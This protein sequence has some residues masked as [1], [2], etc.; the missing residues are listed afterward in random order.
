MSRLGGAL[1]GGILVLLGCI[2]VCAFIFSII[3][4]VQ[5]VFASIFHLTD[6]GIAVVAGLIFWC[7]CGMIGGALYE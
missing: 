1:I 7:V 4:F 3:W 5:S 2:A 6:A